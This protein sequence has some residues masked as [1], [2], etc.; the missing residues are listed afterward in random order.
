MVC[1]GITLPLP[2]LTAYFKT[3]NVATSHHVTLLIVLNNNTTE[4]VPVSF[5]RDVPSELYVVH[6][7]LL[8]CV[9]LFDAAAPI[10]SN[11]GIPILL[12]IVSFV[13]A[14][15]LAVNFE[16]NSLVIDAD[17]DTI[18][19]VIYSL[20]LIA[21][22]LSRFGFLTQSCHQTTKEVNKIVISVQRILALSGA[23][24]RVECGLETFLS[25][26]KEMQNS[27]VVCGFFKLNLPLLGMVIGL[28]I[29]YTVI[30]FQ[31]QA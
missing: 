16:L 4:I 22:S 1:S 24:Y 27:T 28:I 31:L 14:C 9:K 6:K 20:L 11:F 23:R 18:F 7:T 5:L 3:E 2:Y 12:E 8:L 10:S 30:L 17:F 25:Q 13:T 21:A 15:V 19:T 29:S 26:M